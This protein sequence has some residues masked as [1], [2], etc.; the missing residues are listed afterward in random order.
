MLIG[1]GE[2]RSAVHLH[3]EKLDV[4]RIHYPEQVGEACIRFRVI[5]ESSIGKILLVV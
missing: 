2:I 3:Q 4:L 1:L 5:A